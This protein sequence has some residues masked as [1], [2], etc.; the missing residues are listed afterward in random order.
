MSYAYAYVTNIKPSHLSLSTM[1]RVSINGLSSTFK[2]YTCLLI[3]KLYSLSNHSS[4]QLLNITLFYI[5]LDFPLKH[6]KLYSRSRSIYFFSIKNSSLYFRFYHIKVKTSFAN[7]CCRVGFIC[8]Q[9][10]N[11]SSKIVKY[12]Y[13]CFLIKFTVYVNTINTLLKC[14][15]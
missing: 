4:P 5:Q 10:Q 12:I 11:Y 3:G 8:V 9:R 2:L 6:N 15:C 14:N 7:E 13:I 1:G